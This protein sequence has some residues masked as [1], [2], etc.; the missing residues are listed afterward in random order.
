MIREKRIK[1]GRLLEADFYP[2]FSNGSKMPTRAKKEKPSTEEQS[3]YNRRQAGKKL[4]RLV[5]LNFDSDDYFFH[6]TYDKAH[7]PDDICKAKKDINNYLR[8]VKRRRAKELK[9]AE[10]KV[11]SLREKLKK[12][13][14]ED[15]EELLKAQLKKRRKLRQPL[16]Y[17]YVV[18]KKR[19]WHFHLFISGG[20]DAETLKSLWGYGI[21][22]RADHYS[23]DMFGPES[24]AA[25]LAKAPEGSRSFVC[26]KNLK[27][28]QPKYKDGGITRG[29]V[30]QMAQLRPDDAAYWERKY[31]GYRFVRCYPRYNRYNGHWYMS[32]VM[33]KTEQKYL[34]EWKLDADDWLVEDFGGD[35]DYKKEGTANLLQ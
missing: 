28:P 16:K 3:A 10:G 15:L 6:V 35:F 23:P 24:A 8:K 11:K 22:L 4:I 17:I 29:G 1:S 25:Y 12:C 14:D 13:P 33:Y 19:A 31:R 2:V 7:A 5:N 27:K 9:L 30:A 34:P 18:E 20:L 21:R 32:V 26:S